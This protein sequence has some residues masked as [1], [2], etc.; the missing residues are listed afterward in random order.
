MSLHTMQVRMSAVEARLSDVEGDYGR[1]I[2][3]LR[4]DVT[5]LTIGVE[6]ILDHMGSAPR[7]RRRGRRAA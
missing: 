2:Y 3:D 6:R 4:R 5:A 7:H 1:T